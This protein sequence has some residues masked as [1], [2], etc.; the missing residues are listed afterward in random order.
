MRTDRGSAE[1]RKKEGTPGGVP[2]IISR[3]RRDPASPHKWVPPCPRGGGAAL[4]LE[5]K[6]GGKWR[7]NAK[8]LRKDRLYLIRTPFRRFPAEPRTAEAIIAPA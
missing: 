4:G 6:A 7:T 1:P 8:P 3:E 5:R 2:S